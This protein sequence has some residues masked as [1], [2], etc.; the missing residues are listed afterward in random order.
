MLKKINGVFRD[1]LNVLLLSPKF[2]EKNEQH[3]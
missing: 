1:E 2:S 3:K